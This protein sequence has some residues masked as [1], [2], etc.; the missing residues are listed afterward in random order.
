M[1]MKKVLLLSALAILFSNLADAQSWQWGKRG[2]SADNGGGSG[3]RETVTDMATDPNGNVYIL[4]YAGKTALNFDGH[5]KTGYSRRGW[6]IVSVSCNGT[7]RWSKV[8]GS[9]NDEYGVAIKTDALG[10]VYVLGRVSSSNSLGYGHFDTDTAIGYSEKRIALVKYDTSGNYK[11]LRRPEAD[12][13]TG[14]GSNNFPFDLAVD[15]NGTCHLYCYLTPGSFAN[16]GFVNTTTGAHVLKYDASG[17]YV[18]HV[19][20]AISGGNVLSYQNLRMTHSPSGKYYFTGTSRNILAPALTINS[21]S[22]PP[23]FI[24]AFNSS[25][26]F[27][28]GKKAS[29][30]WNIYGRP[31][32]D[33]RGRIFISSAAQN[34]ASF[35]GFTATTANVGAGG[36]VVNAIDTN[37][38]MLWNTCARTNGSAGGQ[39]I[40]TNGTEVAIAGDYTG[41]VRWTG[42]KDSLNLPANYGGNVLFARLNAATG[43]FIKQDSLYS[44]SGYIERATGIAVDGHGNYYV[45][46]Y[47]ETQINVA[48]DTLSNGGETDFFVAK[49]GLPCGCTSA[50]TSNFSFGYSGK[51]VQFT[52]NGSTAQVDSVVWSFGDGQKQTV[53]S[54]FTAP[55]T[56]T[57]TTSGTYN[58]CAA[59]YAYCGTATICKNVTA[60][61]AGAVGSLSALGNIR[62]YPNPASTYIFIEGA[63]GSV[64]T[65]TNNIGQRAMQFSISAE[66]DVI[67]I[68]ILPAGMYILQLTDA[69]GNG[70]AMTVVKE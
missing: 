60:T 27:L 49:Y 42:A 8:I 58:V 25:G 17:N 1:L 13:I 63:K 53:K 46:G 3:D 32:L 68:S 23:Q 61:G 57:Y 65:I 47:F 4:A 6:F 2:G 9:Y 45:G 55:I 11:W 44:P 70:G 64:A 28:W 24:V 30:Y 69:K 50:P 33:A 37:G 52:Y 5:T 29:G 35:N 10:G 38:T 62:V 39:A 16:G 41:K 51:A 18:G 43:A 26:N 48:H 14:A 12:T 67:D 21:T 7:Y 15:P 22:Y 54:G 40:I 34:G 20:L 66:K 19:D 36:P 31:A 59:V 56:H